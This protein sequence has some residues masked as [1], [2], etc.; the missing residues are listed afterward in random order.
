MPFMQ[1]TQEEGC[2]S[3][4]HPHS[5]KTGLFFFLIR[6]FLHLHFKCYPQSPPDPLPPHPP[7]LGFLLNL[8]PSG[9]DG[10]G[11]EKLGGARRPT[12]ALFR[13]PMT[14]V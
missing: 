13:P 5:F 8:N 9:L 12:E 4:T 1:R 2:S 14:S 3:L 6:Y 11:G 7:R 10:G